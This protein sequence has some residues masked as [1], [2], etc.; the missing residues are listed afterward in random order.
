MRGHCAEAES[1]NQMLIQSVVCARLLL[2]CDT[3]LAAVG[4]PMAEGTMVGRRLQR[5]LRCQYLHQLLR[6]FL[7]NLA[8]SPLAIRVVAAK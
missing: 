4:T 7:D 3:A 1:P 6:H 2:R 5:C 8:E